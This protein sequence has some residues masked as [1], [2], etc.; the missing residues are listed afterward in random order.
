MTHKARKPRKPI[1]GRRKSQA[2]ELGGLGIPA[3][4]AGTLDASKFLRGV[5]RLSSYG[6][7]APGILVNG[8]SRCL[9][10]SSTRGIRVIVERID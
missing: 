1:G 7:V 5:A 2:R 4:R 3:R 9:I 10:V 6:V 8:V